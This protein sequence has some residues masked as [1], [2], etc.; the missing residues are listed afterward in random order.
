MSIT[1]QRLLKNVCALAWNCHEWM[2]IWDSSTVV[3]HNLTTEFYLL[4]QLFNTF[5][6]LIIVYLII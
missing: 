6:Y 4:E 3:A 1:F 2:K 5:I